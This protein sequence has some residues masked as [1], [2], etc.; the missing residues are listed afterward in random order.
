MP[1]L[2][3]ARSAKSAQGVAP[4]GQ[5]LADPNAQSRRR[6][7]AYS[8]AT[9]AALEDYVASIAPGGPN[10]PHVDLSHANLAVGGQTFRLQC[11]ACHSWSGVGGALYQRDAPSLRAASATQI[12]EAVRTGPGQMPAFG[13]AA[14][15]ADQINALVAYLRYLD[16]PNNRGGQPLWYLGPVAEGAVAL[17]VGLGL[18]LL[19]ARW[20]GERG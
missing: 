5:Q 14:V 16:H 13:T 17:I 4:A 19:C 7:P 8:P 3:N 1:L 6:T 15:P 9:I 11:A 2:A 20:I 10:I 12:A 18:L